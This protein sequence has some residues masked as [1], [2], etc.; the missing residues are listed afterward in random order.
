MALITTPGDLTANSYA[1]LAEA[2]AYHAARGNTTWT[3]PTR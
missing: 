1:S 3:G 2:A